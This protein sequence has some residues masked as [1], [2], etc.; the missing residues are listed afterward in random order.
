MECPGCETGASSV[1]K[2]SESR[3]H[4]ME[5][6]DGGPTALTTPTEDADDDD[7]EDD[8]DKDDDDSRGGPTGTKWL[9]EVSKNDDIGG[10]KGAS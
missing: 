6:D 4:N 1:T 5:D 2:S 10:R 9:W 8:N 7:N 3:F